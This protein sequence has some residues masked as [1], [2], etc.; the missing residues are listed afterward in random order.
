MRAHVYDAPPV[1]SLKRPG[2]PPGIDGLLAVALA[3]DPDERMQNATAFA[4]VL[5]ATLESK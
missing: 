1:P 4:R 2:L 5:D 3:K